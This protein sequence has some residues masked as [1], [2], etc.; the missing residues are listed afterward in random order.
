M[1]GFLLW[2]KQGMYARCMVGRKVFG[3]ILAH[4]EP[5]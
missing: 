5:Q 4:N 3:N 2:F 1:L